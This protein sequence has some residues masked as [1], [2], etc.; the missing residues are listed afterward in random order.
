MELVLSPS[1]RMV[2]RPPT[3]LQFGLDATT[4]GMVRLPAELLPR[5]MKTLNLCQ[6]PVG[7]L[8]EKLIDAGLEKTYATVLIDDLLR[9]GVLR[10]AAVG[11]IAILGT[12]AAANKLAEV[13]ATGYGIRAYLQRRGE[14][15]HAFLDRTRHDMPLVVI[16][17]RVSS[18]RLGS[19]NRRIAQ[20]QT[21]IPAQLFDAHIVIGPLK[22]EGHGPCPTCVEIKAMSKDPEWRTILAQCS[23]PRVDLAT[24]QL[25]VAR[26]AGMITTLHYQYPAPGIAAVRPVPGLILVENPYTTEITTQVLESEL[27]CPDCYRARNRQADKPPLLSLAPPQLEEQEGE[28][29]TEANT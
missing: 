10:R 6:R 15:A 20:Y 28:S 8:V 19:V 1:A 5:V 17:S 7:N 18:R 14:S 13:F 21:I 23:K 9:H 12:C 16:G 24:Q 27:L 29:G 3:Y 11:E 2:V 25:L 4:A 22:L 26:L